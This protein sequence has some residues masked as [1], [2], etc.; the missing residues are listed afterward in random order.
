MWIPHLLSRLATL[1]V[2]SLLCRGL[3]PLEIALRNGEFYV[4][5]QLGHV[6]LVA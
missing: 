3:I 6:S 5:G 4:E 1:Q 2:L